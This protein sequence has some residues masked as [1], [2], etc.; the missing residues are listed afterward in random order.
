M[1]H[2][3][4]LLEF[5]ARERGLHPDFTHDSGLRIDTDRT[6]LRS[7]I[8]NLLV[9]AV[10]H[11]APSSTIECEARAEAGGFRFRIVNRAP[12]LRSDDLA[13]LFEPFWK[14]DPA[15][16]DTSHAGLGLTIARAFAILLD[17]KID[18]RLEE[19]G[20]LSMTLRSHLR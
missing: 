7:I 15:R 19:E 20:R 1:D 9:N 17:M 16:T 11:A 4:R 6:L 3:W 18:A 5:R 2:A 13:H 12:S 14:K 8:T 10:D